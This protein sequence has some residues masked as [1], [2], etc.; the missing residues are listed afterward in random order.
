MNVD[1]LQATILK[2]AIAELGEAPPKPCEP[3]LPVV[4]PQKVVPEAREPVPLKEERTIPALHELLPLV[5]TA[6]SAREFGALVIA[7]VPVRPRG[8]R[9]RLALAARD[10]LGQN[11]SDKTVGYWL[12]PRRHTD[13]Y[14]EARREAKRRWRAENPGVYREYNRRWRAENPEAVQAA[15][16]RWYA[17][18]PEAYSEYCNRRYATE[19]AFALRHATRNRI[20]KALNAAVG[21][22]GKTRPT[23]ELLGCSA[24]EYRIYLEALFEPGMSWNNRGEWHIDHIVPVAAFDLATDEGQRRAFVYTNT[25]PMWA[26]ENMTKGSL[27]NGVRHRFG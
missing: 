21:S 17:A 19:P 4:A 10:A 27:H 8:T 24:E 12:S 22:P 16:R 6:S 5:K 14:A 1:D 23:L 13:A 25:R 26:A 20:H 15:Q 18:N 7:N 11:W 9:Q 3:E 2:R